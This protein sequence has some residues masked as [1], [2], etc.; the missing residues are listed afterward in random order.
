MILLYVACLNHRHVTRLHNGV[1]REVEVEGVHPAIHHSY[2][3]VP[4]PVLP[5]FTQ[6]H[7][8][9]PPPATSSGSPFPPQILSNGEFAHGT[10]E[11][12][13]TT[14]ALKTRQS[15]LPHCPFHPSPFFLPNCPTSPRSTP[16]KLKRFNLEQDLR[17]R[18]HLRSHHPGQTAEIQPRL[19]PS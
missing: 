11:E 7:N 18:L 6:S 16:S 14:A 19:S 15:P 5:T 13:T 9:N 17:L 4:N 3:S 1:R 12:L 2:S 10:E 8:Y